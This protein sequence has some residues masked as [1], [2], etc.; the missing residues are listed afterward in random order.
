MKSRIGYAIQYERC[1]ALV[2][3]LKTSAHFLRGTNA[4]FSHI[5]QLCVVHNIVA[6]LI[7]LFTLCYMGY[8]EYR[9]LW[10]LWCCECVTNSKM[11]RDLTGL[12]VPFCLKQIASLEDPSTNLLKH[13]HYQ[14]H[15]IWNV[16]ELTGV[17][18]TF[19]HFQWIF[20]FFVT[21]LSRDLSKNGSTTLFPFC[22]GLEKWSSTKLTYF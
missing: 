10:S 16:E 8:L 1:S 17:I 3:L 12:L 5:Q 6:M 18:S 22:K 9:L 11:P 13:L 21:L 14:P 7:M 2:Y 15:I 4:T 20:I 19:L